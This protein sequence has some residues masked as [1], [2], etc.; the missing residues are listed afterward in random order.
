MTQTV[1]MEQIQ[2]IVLSGYAHLP[3]AAFLFFRIHDAARCRE[4]LRIILPEVLSAALWPTA[5]DGTKKKPATAL[6]LAF[7]YK[8]LQALE[9]PEQALKTFPIEFA[10]GQA[11]RFQ[12]L[13]DTGESAPEHWDI[14]GPNTPEIHGVLLL[15]GHSADRLRRLV[16][17]QRGLIQDIREGIEEIHLEHGHREA[18]GKE[19]FGFRDGISQPSIE[20]MRGFNDAQIA[21]AAGEVLLGYLNAYGLY[22]EGPAVP[23][24]ED[25]NQVLQSFPE[26][27]LDNYRDFGRNG[28]YLVYRKLEQDVAG[29]WN[30][31]EE[32]AGR[33]SAEMLHLAAKFLGR[34]PSG[35]PIAIT[36]DKD[37]PALGEKNDF[38][39]MEKD[40]EGYRC[41]VGAHIRR[42]NPRDSRVNDHPDESLNT[43][44][45]HRIVR[46]GIP[47]G[48]PLFHR[49]ALDKGIVPMGLKNDR[50]ERGFHFWA[51]N[52]AISRQ[53]EFVQQ[54]WCNSA[55]FNAQF[56][57]AD[58]LIGPNSGNAVMTL[59]A[60]P[61]RRRIRNVPGFITTRGGEYFFMPGLSALHYLA[62]NAA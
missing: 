23:A 47:Y 36:P 21:V 19:H 38:L 57:T 14:G 4:W 32:E 43:S 44:S 50:R 55:T 24:E 37:V 13:C 20:G 16:E 53:F 8:G 25:P 45:R 60:C 34:W 6:N 1:D 9:L 11:S 33:D 22:S 3:Y 56:D 61:V 18:D 41:P 46:R 27:A 51:L 42:A 12:V 10:N 40:P 39:Y 29:F 17:I 5:P 31:I 62:Q 30:F 59:Q 28:T 52:A 54:T 15:Y 49:A 26:G 48:P 7:S 2:G 35:A 58:P